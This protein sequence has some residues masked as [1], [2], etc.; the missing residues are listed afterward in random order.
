MDFAL[1]SVPG[2]G[3]GGFNANALGALR[4]GTSAVSAISTFMMSQEQAGAMRLEAGDE[5]IAARGDYVQAQQKTDQITRAYNNVVGQQVSDAAAGGID[6]GSG[7][8]VQAGY[9]ARERADQAITVAQSSAQTDA[10]LRQSR[11]LMLSQS[12]AMTQTAGI[13]SGIT[14]L[15]KGGLQ[16]AQIGAPLPGGD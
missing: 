13:L 6:V 3:G 5:E 9:Q 14:D 15:T 1:D 11:A 16:W 7:S 4:M 8:V 12:A 2:G 10:A